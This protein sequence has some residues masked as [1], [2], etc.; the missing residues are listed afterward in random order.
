MHFIHSFMVTVAEPGGAG[1]FFPVVTRRAAALISRMFFNSFFA[2]D[3]GFPHFIGRLGGGCG[4]FG[5]GR[6]CSVTYIT[7]PNPAI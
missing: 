4:G 6:I 7:A 3:G 5:Q 2:V 1:R